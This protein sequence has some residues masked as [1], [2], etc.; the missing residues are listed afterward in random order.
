MPVFYLIYFISFSYLA[1]TI[2]LFWHRTYIYAWCFCIISEFC[3]F[4]SLILFGTKVCFLSWIVWPREDIHFCFLTI[5]LA[6][7][8]R[9]SLLF[10]LKS[11]SFVSS[12]SKFILILRSCTGVKCDKIDSCFVG[13]AA[14]T[15]EAAPG[16]TNE[17]YL[18]EANA[19]ALID[20]LL[21]YAAFNG[22][23][24]VYTESDP[25]EAGSLPSV[26]PHILMFLVDKYTFL[27]FPLTRFG[28]YSLPFVSGF[29]TSLVFCEAESR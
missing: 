23:F 4:I 27:I 6:Y 10:T 12:K 7:P 21:V 9:S 13:V 26:T 22:G 19:A 20:C 11:S 14:A 18:R 3:F 15:T 25:A 29:L 1:F 16:S 2:F 5:G 17:L 24:L 28:T 8:S